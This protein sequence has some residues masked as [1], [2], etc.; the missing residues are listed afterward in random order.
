MRLGHRVP[1]IPKVPN[2]HHAFEDDRKGPSM[3]NSISVKSSEVIFLDN[4]PLS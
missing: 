2:G 4:Q 3:K 1:K